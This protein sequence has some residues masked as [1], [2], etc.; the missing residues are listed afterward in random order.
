[1]SA[2]GSFEVVIK[3]SASNLEE[4]KR[5]QMAPPSEVE[6]VKLSKQDEDV[7]ARWGIPAER[8][9]RCILALRYGRERH[10]SEG[11]ALGQHATEFLRV[12]GES[13][14]LV[15]VVREDDR[16]RWVLRIDSPRGIVGV[17]VPYELADD[18]GEFAVLAQLNRLQEIVLEGVGRSDLIA[19][20]PS[21]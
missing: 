9:A 6:T 16:L 4:W 3:G 13:Y 21:K 8:Y 19:E 17:P 5:A 12:A 14:K 2:S 7:A 11:R 15:S 18:V 10:E 20:A 1:M